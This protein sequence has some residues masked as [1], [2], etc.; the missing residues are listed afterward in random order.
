[1]QKSC[2]TVLYVCTINKITKYRYFFAFSCPAD[3]SFD[4]S[5][6]INVTRNYQPNIVQFQF[7]AFAWTE[8]L[9]QDQS[10]YI[11]C[12]TEI[13]DTNLEEGCTDLV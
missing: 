4:P 1:M 3:N 6:A 2:S 9:D 5:N 10:M 12:D 11:H 7:L 8:T 13:C